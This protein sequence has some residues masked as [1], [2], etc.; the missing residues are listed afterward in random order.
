MVNY[1]NVPRRRNNIRPLGYKRLDSKTKMWKGKS[2]YERY[3]D[4]LSKHDEMES[5]RQLSRSRNGKGSFSRK[6]HAK[7]S[8]IRR[9]LRSMRTRFTGLPSVTDAIWVKEPPPYTRYVGSFKNSDEAIVEVRKLIDT[10]NRVSEYRKSNRSIMTSTRLKII[11]LMLDF[12]LCS[13]SDILSV[14]F[15]CGLVLSYLEKYCGKRTVVN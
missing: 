12:D 9:E 10:Y 11:R 1:I 13:R 14:C 4:L 7:I 3:M 6:E 2:Q 15:N 5:K 8:K